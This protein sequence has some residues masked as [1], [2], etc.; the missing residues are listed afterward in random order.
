MKFGAFLKCRIPGNR[1]F[2]RQ[3]RIGETVFAAAFPE[4][5]AKKAGF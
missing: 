1:P 4:F 2:I 5:S 3:P